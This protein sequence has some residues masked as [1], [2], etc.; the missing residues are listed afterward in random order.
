M[1]RSTR[2]AKIGITEEKQKEL[3]AIVQS[4]TAPLRKIQRANILLKYAAN[5]PISTIQNEIHVSRPVIYK[6][7]DKTLAM[8]LEAGLKDLYHSPKKPIITEEA[9]M[10]IINLAC[11]KPKEYGYAAEIWSRRLLAKHSREYGPQAGHTCLANA[12]KATVQRILKEHPLRPDKMA[13]YLNRRDPDFVSKMEDILMVYKEV[14]LW[15]DQAR[16]GQ[17]PPVITV[18]VDEKPGVQAIQNMAPDILPHPEKNSRLMREH[19]YKRLGTVSILAGLDLHTGHVTAQVHDRHRSKEFI[20]LLKELDSYYPSEYTIRLILDNHSTHISKETMSY[21]K[22]RP[23]RFI[24]IHTPKHGSWLNLV[25]TLF[26]KIA[27]TFLK[28]IRVNSLEDLKQRIMQ[29]IREIN[30][31]PIIHRWKKFEITLK[32]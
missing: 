17:S 3:Q 27:R 22:T 21:L 2:R 30:E 23:N 10:W 25:E 20:S 14:N 15:N 9:K 16:E 13:Y 24:Y 29:G 1:P 31:S 6:C 7:I 12:A 32:Y 26:G 11:S 19:Q 8:G 5:T 18:S 28:H 4:R